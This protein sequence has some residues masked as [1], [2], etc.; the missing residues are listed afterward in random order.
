[1]SAGLPRTRPSRLF[2][3]SGYIP[4]IDR[5]GVGGAIAEDQRPARPVGSIGDGGVGRHAM[6]ENGGA[7][8]SFNRNC[9]RLINRLHHLAYKI[10]IHHVI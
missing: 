9:L 4:G 2:Q 3:L 10:S 5:E 6:H 8:L 7:G 1:M